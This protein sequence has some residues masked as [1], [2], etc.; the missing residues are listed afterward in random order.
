MEMSIDCTIKDTRN[1]EKH[2]SNRMWTISISV[3]D[4]GNV[5]CTDFIIEVF[6]K[7]SDLRFKIFW[8]VTDTTLIKN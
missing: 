6:L 4:E 7:F 3:T 1:R 2:L 8:R 5:M